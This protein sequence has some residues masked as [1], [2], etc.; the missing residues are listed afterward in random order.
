M[1]DRLAAAVVT[2]GRSVL[3]VTSRALN[4]IGEDV[5]PSQF[6]ALAVLGSKGEKRLAD[7]ATELSVTPSTV[8][9]MCE[10]LVRKGLAER[11]R[12]ALDKRE[13]L[14]GLTATGKQLVDE[15]TSAHQ[16][17]VREVLAVVPE[18]ERIHLYAA[19]QAVTNAAAS[20]PDPIPVEDP[21]EQ[22]D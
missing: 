12:D 17:R 11:S 18:N 15:V 19:L 5:T 13:V 21:E 4:E 1:L 7:L 8:T 9:R 16:V 6:R 20:A 2:A 10:R 3:G 22:A 14:V